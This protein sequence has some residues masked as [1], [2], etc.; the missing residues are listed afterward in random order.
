MLDHLHR[1]HDVELPPFPDEVLGRAVA[2]LERVPRGGR[3]GGA[4]GGG[5]DGGVGE[6]EGGVLGGVG[7]GGEDVGRGGVDREGGG[8][9][10]GERLRE[11][12][13]DTVSPARTL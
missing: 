2:V 13:R 11:R 12:A 3:G 6:G 7:L 10:A 9:E 1:A 4:G 8:A 5:G